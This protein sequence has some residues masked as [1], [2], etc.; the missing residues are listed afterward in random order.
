MVFF[1]VSTINPH[2]ALLKGA[3]NETNRE[4]ILKGEKYS[5]L[6]SQPLHFYRR[7]ADDLT[8]PVEPTLIPCDFAGASS[9]ILHFLIS[10]LHF[11]QKVGHIE[12]SR[13]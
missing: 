1:Q 10:K 2:E 8:L 3:M 12:Q 7:F 4:L 5:D 13:N 11:R 9:R 6:T